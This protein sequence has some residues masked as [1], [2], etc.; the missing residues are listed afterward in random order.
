M[1]RFKEYLQEVS[2]IDALR[3]KETQ[4]Q[5]DKYN[6]DKDAQYKQQNPNGPPLADTVDKL[7]KW[8]RGTRNYE[9]PIKPPSEYIK[10]YIQKG[11]GNWLDRPLFKGIFG[12]EK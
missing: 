4:A 8:E 9:P 12:D 6:A 10:K 1:L 5:R 3:G 2:S 11:S 7:D